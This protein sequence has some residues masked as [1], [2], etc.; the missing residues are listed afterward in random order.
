MEAGI[1]KNAENNKIKKIILFLKLMHT[2]THLIHVFLFAMQII[3]SLGYFIK[4][5]PFIWHNW[6]KNQNLL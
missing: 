2:H 4:C 1:L 6:K 3:T 5:T